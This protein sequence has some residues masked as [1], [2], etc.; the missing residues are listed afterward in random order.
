M[1]RKTITIEQAMPEHDVTIEMPEQ[2]AVPT[3]SAP[4]GSKPIQAPANDE[5][6]V[7]IAT[8]WERFWDA[9]RRGW[10][11]K[12]I[13]ISR[14]IDARTAAAKAK[15]RAV[16]ALAFE[17]N[18]RRGTLPSFVIFVSRNEQFRLEHLHAGLAIMDLLESDG[19]SS[20]GWPSI[21]AVSTSGAVSNRAVY[22]GKEGRRKQDPVKTFQPKT[23]RAPKA[24]G[25]GGM[26]R[27]ADEVRW[28]ASIW[29][30]FVEVSEAHGSEL[31]GKE[32]FGDVCA[33]VIRSDST[34]ADALK[35]HIRI[36][37]SRGL[38]V[39]VS[40]MVAGLDAVI[41]MFAQRK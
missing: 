13:D 29:S 15:E 9:R 33:D 30:R 25:D 41:P 31:S 6:F 28:K 21:Q 1:P 11:D 5:G 20:S 22:A 18:Q 3:N 24:S 8:L 38:E 39:A 36:R 40:S 32:K 10:T 19:V 7:D 34:V 23:S 35:R 12:A 26:S 4:I 16:L 37:K 2:A 27:M 17:A 14:A